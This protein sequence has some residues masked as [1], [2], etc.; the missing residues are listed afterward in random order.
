VNDLFEKTI[1]TGVR[2]PPA[3]HRGWVEDKS[4]IK[5]DEV[6]VFFPEATTHPTT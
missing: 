2:L 3:P 5:T 4:K 1:W 6:F